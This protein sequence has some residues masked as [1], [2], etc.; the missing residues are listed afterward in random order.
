MASVA[1]I[2]FSG[3][4]VVVVFVE[5]SVDWTGIAVFS[6]IVELDEDPVN[7]TNSSSASFFLARVIHLLTTIF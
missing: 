1:S 5:V 6:D 2:I 4:E 7:T 3:F